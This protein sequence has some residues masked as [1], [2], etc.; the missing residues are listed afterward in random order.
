MSMTRRLALLLLLLLPLT[1]H[2]QPTRAKATFA[3]GCFWC[4]EP[5]FEKLKGVVS[6]TSGYTGGRTPR[7]T[8]EQVS[9]GGTG[10]Y[11]SVQ[12][13]YD[14]RQVSYGQLLEVFWK[15]IDPVNAR[16]QFCDEGDQYRAVI[17]YGTPAE[18][19]LAE[20]SKRRIEQTKRIRVVT[21]ILP[22]AAFFPAEEYHQDYAK[23]NPVRYR[24]Y[25]FN[26]GR[27]RR[28]QEVWGS[29]PEH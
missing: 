27:D 18:K 3:G 22:A 19:K 2:A 21:A 7:P 25:R 23:K 1:L 17:F 13:V 8:Y 20:E 6:V 10:H 9:A 12:V 16:G 5:P 4:M 29:S 26:C 15:N 11:E 28:L 24:F 14:P